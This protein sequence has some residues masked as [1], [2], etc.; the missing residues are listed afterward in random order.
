MNEIR[1]IHL[2]RQAYTV[3][4]EAYKELKEYLEAI[5]KKVGKEVAEEVELRMVELLTARGVTSK[6]V[7]LQKDVDYLKEQLGT[8]G[9]FGDDDAD[10]ETVSAGE[11]ETEGQRRLFR[12]PDNAMIA[13]VAAGLANY[14]DIDVIIVRLLFIA[15]VFFGG[16]G[17]L[18]YLVLWVLVPEAKTNSERLQMQGMAVNV[19][20]IKR[21]IDQADV[22]GVT[23]RVTSFVGRIVSVLVKAV[24]AAVGV[25]F[26]LAGIVALLGAG[27]AAA[28]GL[29]RGVDIAGVP[30][31]PVGAE[32]V[33]M[34]ICACVIA[35]LIGGML[36]TS[37]VALVRR[38]WSMPAWALAAIIGTFIAAVSLGAAFGADIAPA[39]RHRY[40][41]LQHTRTV[42]VQP[43]KRLHIL[44]NDVQYR[45]EYGSTPSVQIHSFGSVN[46][47]AVKVNEKDGTLTI[48]ARGLHQD[49]CNTFCPYGDSN[50]EVVVLTPDNAGLPIDAS[51]G[52]EVTV[53]TNIKEQ[54]DAPPTAP[55]A[56]KAPV[57]PVVRDA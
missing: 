27:L 1:N 56:P 26:I 4:A 41:A 33:T 8:P 11:E 22:P 13:G 16:S 19:D 52:A 9:D 37:G 49:A 43:I 2:G 24:L 55:A 51:G 7:V 47:Q 25:G 57:A 32:A 14:F 42:S 29:V 30:I 15:L 39:I 23:R 38:K 54:P 3:S 46:T 18:I 20:N 31:F 21:V 44:G 12:D 17:V 48:D 50:V 28:F 5:Q 34:L 45:I 10:S 40:E 6:K 35:G 53:R 36:A